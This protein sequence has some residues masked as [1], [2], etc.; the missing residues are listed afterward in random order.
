M[1]GAAV[2]SVR[3][4]GSKPRTLVI[5]WDAADA[6]LVEQWCAEGLL[7]NI[8]RM[9][10]TRNLGAHGNYCLNGARVRMAFDIHRHC[11]G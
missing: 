7:P 9:K 2:T 10:A 8:A 3:P 11:A 6:E 1:N 4:R 5:G